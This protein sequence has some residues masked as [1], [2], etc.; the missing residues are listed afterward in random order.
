M[1]TKFKILMLCVIAIFAS[2]N[3]DD[4]SNG[5]NDDN[6]PNTGYNY[7]V[8]VNRD[9]SGLILDTSGNA[10]VGATVTIGS[11][12]AQTNSKGLFIMQ[13]ASVREKFAFV[14]V[15][16]SGFI[17]GSRTLV[18]T[19]GLNRVNIMMIPKVPVSSINSGSNSTVSLPNGT[20]VKFDG[21]FKDENG[22]AYSGSVS[23]AMYH[24]KPSNT[25][26]QEIMPGSLLATNSNSEAKILETLGMMYVDLTGSSGQKLNIA[27]G[28]TAEIT[29][30]IDATQLATAPAT[31]P[32]WSFDE[33]IGM[34]REEGSA[35]K[36][37]N[38]YVG[39]VSHFS[40]WNCDTPLD[41][42]TLNVHAQNSSGQSISNLTISLISSSNGQR[43]TQTDTAGNATG[44][45]PANETLTMNIYNS[46]GNVI[47]TTTIGPFASGSNNTLPTIIINNPSGSSLVTVVGTLKNCSGGNVT[48]G[49]I[50][51]TGLT[52]SN[53]FNLYNI[54]PVT[55]G[56][57]SYTFNTCS[58]GQQFR[59]FGEDF[60]TQQVS[61]ETTFTTAAP[62]T[63]VG[64]I[65]TCTTTN[66]YVSFKIDNNPTITL[67]SNITANGDATTQGFYIYAGSGSTGVVSISSLTNPI[68]GN[69]YTASTFTGE[70]TDGLAA[71]FF[72]PTVSLPS[73]VQIVATH[74]GAVGDYIDLT[75]NGTSTDQAGVQHTITC[76]VHAIRDN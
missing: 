26:L 19:T 64:I 68:V 34:W 66:E 4:S 71:V 41:F 38:K 7:G 72:A 17:T 50:I 69:T 61:T 8:S 75:V 62:T 31:I 76:T 9:F 12:T 33:S 67:I 37:G 14:R 74:I 28:H 51:L 43:G 24:L 13:G 35:T 21:S 45:I 16:K 23:V 3:P 5:G 56:N 46:C 25:Y 29:M 70:F 39:N 58:V 54:I 55:N 52:T 57:F 18:P 48:N 15:T 2:C 47:Y 6:T 22:H 49:Q 44:L 59:V 27:D 10:V 30:E 63:N 73:N 32:L 60:T 20:Q 53:Y 36:V 65:Q 1:K 42:C 11:T 40:W